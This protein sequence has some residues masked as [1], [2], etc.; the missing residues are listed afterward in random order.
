M[1]EGPSRVVLLKLAEHR[2]PYVLTLKS[3]VT[4]S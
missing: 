1:L 4:K 3:A 2:Q